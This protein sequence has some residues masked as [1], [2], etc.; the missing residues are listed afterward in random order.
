MLEGG[1]GMRLLLVEDSARLRELLAERIR[2]AG[3]ELEAVGSIGAAVEASRSIPYDLMLIDLGLPDGDGKSLIRL[4][5]AQGS[6]VPILVLTARGSIDDRVEALGCG[7]DDVLVKP[8]GHVDFLAR[9]RALLRRG[10][11]MAQEP[12]AV[13]SVRFDPT[14]LTVR[15][16]GQIVPVPLR[17]RSLLELLLREPDRVVSKERIEA[18]LS[19]LGEEASP[20]SAELAISSLRMRL[21][22]L[23]TCIAI[24]TIRGAGYLLRELKAHE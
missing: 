11:A 13:G 17:E 10:G 12:I 2:S 23:D 1:F 5:R 8:F 16:E 19:S 4:L 6:S 3:W 21:A 24:E 7:A 15:I 9:C 22:A 20:D 18:A 14:S